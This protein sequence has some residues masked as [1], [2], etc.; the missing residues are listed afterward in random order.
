MRKLLLILSLVLSFV[1]LLGK[2]DDEERRI[3]LEK[4]ISLLDSQLKDAEKK[5]FNA[6]SSLNLTKKK[7]AARKSLV[8]ESDRKLK[9]IEDRMYQKQRQINVMQS[10]LDTLSIYY[11]R[12]VKSAYKNRDA[13]VWY[14]FILSGESIGQGFRRYAYLKNLSTQMN[15]QAQKIQE[16]RDELKREKAQL[17]SIKAD[18]SKER[19]KRQKELDKLKKEESRSRSLVAQLKKDKAKYSRQLAAKRSQMEA[20]KR[21][22]DGIITQSTGKKSRPVDQKLSAQ[23]EANKGKLPWPAEGV[24]VESFGEHNHPVYKNVK[25][26]FN[27][28]I[29]IATAVNAAVKAV[30]DG[31]VRQIIVMPGYNKCVL[32]QHGGY[33]TFY[34]KMGS[35]SVKAGD[36][37]KTGQKIGNVDTI[38]AETQLHFQVWK[39]RRPQDPATWL[40]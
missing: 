22:V 34:C 13:R 8:A 39:G 12:L 20:L 3:K 24:I 5:S 35:V 32:V 1:P 9:R 2:G 26:P 14:M 19:L 38:S 11:K 10:R 33:F 4:E 23:F 16:T 28:G 17:A 21:Q 25:L 15:V 36:K 37:V 31:E 6:L 7:V 18:A 40:Y 30:F 27:N 29:G